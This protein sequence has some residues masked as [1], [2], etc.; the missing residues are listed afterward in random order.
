MGIDHIIAILIL[1]QSSPALLCSKGL[2]VGSLLLLCL[3]FGTIGCLRAR[4]IGP[5]ILSW[6][7]CIWAVLEQKAWIAILYPRDLRTRGARHP[8]S[9]ADFVAPKMPLRWLR[10]YESVSKVLND[11]PL[12]GRE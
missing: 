3:G 2:F 11:P 10:I 7:R 4:S 9:H 8:L 12:V 1:E 6:S 5:L